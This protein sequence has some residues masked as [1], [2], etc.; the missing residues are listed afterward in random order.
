M[1]NKT[2]KLKLS[3]LNLEEAMQQLDSIVNKLEAQ[4]IPLEQSLELF[5]QG[6]QL[7]RF[8]R[9][10]L[11]QMEQKVQLLVN[12]NNQLKIK[13]FDQETQDTM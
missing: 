11:D 3:K 13:P 7:N 12:E 8:C 5:E 10:I 4:D 1:P 6:I 9:D 2:T